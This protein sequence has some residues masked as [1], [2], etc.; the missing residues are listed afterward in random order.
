MGRGGVRDAARELVFGIQN[1]RTPTTVL[2]AVHDS[3]PRS[4][5]ST[6]PFSTHAL[7]RRER[8]RCLPLWGREPALPVAHRLARR[9]LLVDVPHDSHEATLRRRHGQGLVRGACRPRGS[10]TSQKHVTCLQVRRLDGVGGMRQAAKLDR[11]HQFENHLAKQI[12]QL[13]SGFPRMRARTV[14]A[15]CFNITRAEVPILCME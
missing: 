4:D 6:R 9:G 5:P 1:N 14:R 3:C 13:H 10:R 12:W 2:H 7:M 8:P 15:T 11:L